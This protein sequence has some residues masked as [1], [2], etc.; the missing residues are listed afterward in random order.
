MLAAFKKREQ[1]YLDNRKN[2]SSILGQ[3]DN[4]IREVRR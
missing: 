3:Q 1:A 4:D 2:A